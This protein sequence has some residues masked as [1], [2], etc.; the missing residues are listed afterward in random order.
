M[1]EM[2]CEHHRII[3]FWQDRTCARILNTQTQAV[4]DLK[5]TVNGSLDNLSKAQ[6]RVNRTNGNKNQINI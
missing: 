6:C 1:S 2:L 5:L 4:C 3:N